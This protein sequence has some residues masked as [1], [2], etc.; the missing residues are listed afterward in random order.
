VVNIDQLTALE[1]VTIEPSPH[2]LRLLSVM[3]T[4]GCAPAI[5]LEEEQSA[6]QRR[7]FKQAKTIEQRLAEQA[8]GLRKQA[9]S[10]PPGVKRD[11]LIRQARIA[12]TTSQIHLWL[13]SPGL[14]APR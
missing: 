3:R 4:L 12:E 6:T 5:P 13:T 1:A 11:N 14:Q 2:G 8:D 7:R 10:T 9:Q